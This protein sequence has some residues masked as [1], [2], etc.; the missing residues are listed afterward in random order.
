[1]GPVERRTHR[2]AAR[3]VYAGNPASEAMARA[4]VALARRVDLDGS[5]A[6]ALPTA[7][8]HL[9]DCSNPADPLDEIRARG[10]ARWA[11]T[12]GLDL[13]EGRRRDHPAP[14]SR[15]VFGDPGPSPE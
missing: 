8:S 7:L 13:G 1:M 11:A 5:W 10:C 6:H 14:R 12:A 4:A 2:L 9:R 15:R 3:W